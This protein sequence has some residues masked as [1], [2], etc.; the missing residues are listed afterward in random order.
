[1]APENCHPRAEN[2]RNA[3]S[4]TRH[5]NRQAQ[6]FWPLHDC[7]NAGDAV[8]IA[9]PQLAGKTVGL[10]AGGCSQGGTKSARMTFSSLSIV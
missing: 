4:M 10:I 3:E 7:D 9:L 2:G 5:L 6:H 8:G 1:M